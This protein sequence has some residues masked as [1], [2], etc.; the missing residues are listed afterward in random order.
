[1]Q[2]GAT[3]RSIYTTYPTAT[4]SSWVAFFDP[5]VLRVAARRRIAPADA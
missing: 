3:P 1:M 4:L 5:F 2:S